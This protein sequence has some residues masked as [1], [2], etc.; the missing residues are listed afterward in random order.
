M[1]S[2]VVIIDEI[3]N[4]MLDPKKRGDVERFLAD[5][6]A[7]GRAPGVH[8]IIA[9]QRPS[10][11]VVTGLIKANFPARLAFN[12]AS[13]VD[14]RVILDKSDA[15]G[16]GV[17]GRLIFQNEN[18][19][20]LCQAPFLSEALV[21]D[22]VARMVAGEEGISDQQHS[23]GTMDMIGWCIRDNDGYF[24][25]DAVYQQFRA[26]GITHADVRALYAELGGLEML[27]LDGRYWQWSARGGKFVPVGDDGRPTNEV[28]FEDVA[29]WAVAENDCR[30]DHRTIWK[31][32]DALSNVGTRRMIAAHI[33]EELEIDGM[34]YRVERGRRRTDPIHLEPCD[35]VTRDME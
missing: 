3:A 31:Q 35:D 17:P 29:R 24:S 9:T 2:I 10:V 30:L 4:V 34:R 6:A 8:C 27:D 33:G 1:A 15:A 28:T 19:R 5:I 18:R 26:R 12:T 13:Q 32:F 25:I 7:R 14:S 16:L 20:Y 21:D 11:D 23:V 22:V